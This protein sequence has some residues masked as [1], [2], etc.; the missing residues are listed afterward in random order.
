MSRVITFSRTFLAHHPRRGE[1]TYFVEA[2]LTQLGIDY[3]NHEYYIWLVQANPSVSELFLHIFFESLSRD[4]NPK[5]H[6]IRA[7]KKPLKVGDWINPKCWAD[8]PYNKTKDGFWQIKFAPDIQIKKVWDFNVDACG[9]ISMA[10]TGQQLK[11]IDDDFDSLIA[12]HDGLSC[13]DFIQWI[14]MPFY[15][16]NRDSGIMQINCW[17]ENINYE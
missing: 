8:K 13:D 3:T 7:H 2:I 1:P 17:N 16:K 15:K 12:Y 9:V 11:Y 10:K 14:V 6:T 5:S 4:I